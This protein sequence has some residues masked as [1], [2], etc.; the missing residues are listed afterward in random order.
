MRVLLLRRQTT[1]LMA[2]YAEQL[3][4]LLPRHGAYAVVDDGEWIPNDTGPKTDREVTARLK[5]RAEDFDVIH[6]FGYRAAWACAEAFGR[7]K[8]W[9]YTTYDPPTTIHPQLIQ[10]LNK[11]KAGIA[12][13]DHIRYRLADA[14][15]KN[16]QTIFPAI[17]SPLD[18]PEVSTVREVFGLPSDAQVLTT[19]S[20]WTLKSGV[21]KVLLAMQEVWNVIPEAHLLLAGSGPLEETIKKLRWEL[22]K[23]EHVHLSGPPLSPWDPLVAADLLVEPVQGKQFS[24]SVARMMSIGKA[25]LVRDEVGL[26]DMVEAHLSGFIFADDANLASQISEVL[27]MPYTLSSVG[28]SAK[29]RFE[30]RYDLGVQVEAMAERYTQWAHETNGVADSP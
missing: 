13:S 5:N 29:S 1:G 14:G 15:A 28:A 16:L 25:T 6:A 9:V 27:S 20:E 19:S 3:A 23:A 22:P 2:E 17:S 8:P 4:S 30:D 18:L 11:A 24:A 10:R 21:D 12:S 7:Q 26:R